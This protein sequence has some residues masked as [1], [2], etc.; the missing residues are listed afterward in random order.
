MNWSQVFPI[1][2]GAF[3]AVVSSSAT[4]FVTD[5]Y[6]RRTKRSQLNRFLATELS[7][8]VSRIT[9]LL[10]IYAESEKP[11]PTFLVALERA[12][13]L[14]A[15]RRE[16]VYL[17]EIELGQQVLEFYDSVDSAVDM[18]MSMLRLAEKAGHDRF[19]SEEVQKQMSNL[20]GA[21]AL[22]AGLSKH[23]GLRML[24]SR[25]TSHD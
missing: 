16:T 8:C 14:F 21:C 20:E 23:F 24:P 7:S 19:V 5:W 6:E 11:D 2:I 3:L 22:G 4:K 18:I 13:S 25:R 12:T 9:G 17:L 1:L 10:R 15:V